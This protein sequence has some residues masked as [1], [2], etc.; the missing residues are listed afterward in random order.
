MAAVAGSVADELI[1]F[2]RDE[3]GVTRAYVNNGGDI[4]LHLASGQRYRVGLTPISAGSSAREVSALDGDLEVSGEMQVHGVATNRWHGRSLSLG[5]ADSVTVLAATGAAADAGATM[6]ANEV[7]VDDTGIVRRPACAI[8]A[9]R[10]RILCSEASNI[11]RHE[12][13]ARSDRPSISHAGLRTDAGIVPRSPRWR[14]WWPRHRQRRPS[15]RARSRCRHTET[16]TAPMPPAVA[17]PCTCISPLTSR[18]PSSADTSRRLIR[19]RSAYNRRDSAGR[20][21]D[22]GRCR[23]RCSRTPESRRLIPE[24]SNQLI[25]HTAGHSR[26]GRDEL[27]S[28]RPAGLH[29]PARQPVLARMQ[30]PRQEN[31]AI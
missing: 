29:H 27:R 5:I 28:M 30:R 25:R 15:P 16:E 6:I 3:P 22:A 1:G 26:H 7:N 4:A 10:R 18:S 21:R 14:S 17:T 9:S 2:F 12:T 24:K 19:P 31:A 11:H 8:A 20:T 23:P 13:F